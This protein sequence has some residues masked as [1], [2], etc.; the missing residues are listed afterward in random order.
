VGGASLIGVL[1]VIG[2][3]L[4]GRWG[5]PRGDFGLILSS[6]DSP[7]EEFRTLWIGDAGVVP[8]R[9]WALDVPALAE[10]EEGAQL[11][12]ATTFGRSP[13]VENMW[14]GSRGGATEELTT[15]LEQAGDRGADRL[16]ARLAPMG[17]Q[18][19]VVPRRPAPLPYVSDDSSHPD[20]LVD[21][22]A[23]QLD[24]RRIDVVGGIHVYRNTAWDPSSAT[25]VT[26]PASAGVSPIAAVLRLVQL[27]LWLVVIVV[28][29]R[30]RSRA[31]AS[32]P[33]EGPGASDGDPL[34]GGRAG[35]P[36]T[37]DV[38]TGVSP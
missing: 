4:D 3:S 22:L 7:T 23:S 10:P 5:M 6:L 14:P 18:Y 26:E 19:I 1:P 37:V 15:L 12:Y 21:L 34:R 25:A 32:P 13:N 35:G 36:E 11:V 33:F 29:W 2:A 38:R 24:L 31:G 27:G 8:L 17:I 28:V 16:G 20:A 9:G 30:T